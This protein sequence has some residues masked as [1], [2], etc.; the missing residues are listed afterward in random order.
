MLQNYKNWFITS[1]V[2]IDINKLLYSMGTIDYRVYSLFFKWNIKV[3]PNKLL[4]LGIM[5]LLKQ[6]N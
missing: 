3:I 1:S 6:N 2:S 4:R 5:L